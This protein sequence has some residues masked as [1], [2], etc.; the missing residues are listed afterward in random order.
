MNLSSIVHALAKWLAI[1][2]G[3]F[4]VAITV[5]TVVSIVGRS[6]IFAGLGPVPGDFELVEAGTGFAVFAFL[7][8]CQLNRGHASVDLFTN[9]LPPA[10]NRVLDLLWEIVLGFVTF[11]IAWRLWIGMLEKRD[12][13]EIT[14][15]LQIPIWWGMALCAVATVVGVLVAAYMI[16]IRAMEVVQG[17]ALLGPTTGAIH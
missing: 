3:L 2:G 1:I 10:A 7:P 13:G 15:I 5:M 9:Y 8:W 12:Y 16:V 14:F 17:R 4:L 11:L 6:L